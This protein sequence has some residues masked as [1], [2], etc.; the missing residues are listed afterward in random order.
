MKYIKWIPFSQ[1][2]NAY[3]NC[4]IITIMKCYLYF[5]K[6]KLSSASQIT[7][8]VPEIGHPCHVIREQGHDNPSSCMFGINTVGIN[9]VLEWSQR[10]YW[11]IH[12][13]FINKIN[14]LPISG[15]KIHVDWQNICW[16]FLFILPK[17]AKEQV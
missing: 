16:F 12:L 8:Y 2:Q 9:R 3:V 4:C 5:G 15:Y 13:F 7:F 14:F 17:P 11:L 6:Q 1:M 10:S